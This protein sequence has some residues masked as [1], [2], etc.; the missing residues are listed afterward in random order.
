[1]FGARVHHCVIPTKESIQ[2]GNGCGQV[3]KV[4]LI[5]AISRGGL[6][7]AQATQLHISFQ[8][9][10]NRFHILWDGGC[11]L[12]VLACDRVRNTEQ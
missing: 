8:A 3:A 11:P 10:D 6:S 7:G 12:E 4:W 2:V 9:G 5:A 1:M